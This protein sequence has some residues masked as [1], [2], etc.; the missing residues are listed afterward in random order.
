MKFITIFW[1]IFSCSS[2]TV[3]VRK[4]GVKRIEIVQSSYQRPDFFISKNIEVKK[5]SK[6]PKRSIASAYDEKLTNRHLYFLSLYGQQKKLEMLLGKKSAVNSCPSF[7]QV[8]LEN[9]EVK[10]SSAV[11]LTTDVSLGEHLLEGDFVAFYPVLAVPYSEEKDL[12]T[13]MVENNWSNTNYH[14]K[15]GL[16]HYYSLAQKELDQLCDTGVSDGY[17]IFEN[18][19]TYF[20]EEQKL[21]QSL[22]SLKALLKVPVLANIMIIDNLKNPNFDHSILSNFEFSLLE[23][24]NITWFTGYL[25]QLNTKRKLILGAKDKSKRTVLSLNH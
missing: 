8:L 6:T 20:K 7:H 15:K 25:D 10:N 23:R 24:S 19:V 22:N 2:P 12:Y 9:E 14:L 13:K 3:I 11:S 17:Y 5:V 16:E 21:G 1:F 18:L 4:D